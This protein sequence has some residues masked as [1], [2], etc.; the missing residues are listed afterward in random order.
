MSQIT[1]V[2]LYVDSDA[3]DHEPEAAALLL[4]IRT[5]HPG[6]RDHSP[7]R[8]IDT[9]PIVGDGKGFTSDVYLGVFNY[10]TWD[11]LVTYLE[12]VPWESGT[13]VVA[14]ISGENGQ[15]TIMRKQ[16]GGPWETHP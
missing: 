10:L 1:E 6:I 9:E 13:S 4:P 8:R 15:L 14:I 2:V 12:A 3:A 11:D 7:F 5:P 16:Y